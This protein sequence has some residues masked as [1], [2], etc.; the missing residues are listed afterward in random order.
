MHQATLL[1]PGAENQEHYC[2]VEVLSICRQLHL[3]RHYFVH[4]YCQN[5]QQQ[6]NSNHLQYYADFLPVHRE[7]IFLLDSGTRKPHLLNLASSAALWLANDESLRS[8][9]MDLLLALHQ[10]QIQNLNKGGCA[11]WTEVVVIVR[12]IEFGFLFVVVGWDQLRC[13]HGR[14]PRNL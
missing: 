5:P 13:R 8:P 3:L 2:V 1:Q 10:L 7:A 6:H 12:W 14:F 4:Y 9:Q 11:H